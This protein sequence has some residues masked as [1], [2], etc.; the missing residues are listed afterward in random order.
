MHGSTDKGCGRLWL[1]VLHAHSHPPQGSVQKR[2]FPHYSSSSKTERERS[3]VTMVLLAASLE[4]AF[5]YSSSLPI[6]AANHTHN[7]DLAKKSCHAVPL[8]FLSQSQDEAS[9]RLH[10]R[11]PQKYP[12]QPCPRVEAAITTSHCLF[13]RSPSAMIL[14]IPFTIAEMQTARDTYA[15]RVWHNRGL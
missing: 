7:H 10:W 1:M 3:A 8:N 15:C 11:I 5:P 6:R 2:T 4:H 12:N 14:F 13:Q 9:D